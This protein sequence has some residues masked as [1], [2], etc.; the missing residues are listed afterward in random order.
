MWF[1]SCDSELLKRLNWDKVKFW[2]KRIKIILK[3]LF[4]FLI[5]KY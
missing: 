5:S 4:C 1:V 3:V 2:F